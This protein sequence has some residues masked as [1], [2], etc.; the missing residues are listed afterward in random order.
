[1]SR[2]PNGTLKVQG[3]IAIFCQTQLWKPA[4]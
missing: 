2:Q 3:C 1:M 4:G